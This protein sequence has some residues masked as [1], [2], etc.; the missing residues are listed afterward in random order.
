MKGVGGLQAWKWVF[1]LE[2]IPS[3]IMAPFVLWFLPDKPSKAKWLT[4]EEKHWIDAKVAQESGGSER[5]Q[6]MSFKV[7]LTDTRI[8]R[9]CLVFF[10][11]AVAG[12]SIGTFA[13][14]LYKQISH[15][16]WDAANHPVLADA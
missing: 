11:L 4:D 8:L 5:L 15:G 12:S 10:L 6:H 16:Q 14:H 1:L 13:P 2:G 7:A 9:L 3:V